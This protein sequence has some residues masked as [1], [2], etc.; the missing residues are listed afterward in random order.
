MMDKV[1]ETSGSQLTGYVHKCMHLVPTLI[2]NIQQ[3]WKK[4]STNN[5]HEQAEARMKCICTN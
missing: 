5:Q 2:L 4:Q 1:L 3:I